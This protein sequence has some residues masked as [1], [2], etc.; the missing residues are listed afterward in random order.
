MIWLN[1]YKTLPIAVPKRLNK[2]LVL[3][4]AVGNAVC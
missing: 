3:G 1:I 2:R 4:N